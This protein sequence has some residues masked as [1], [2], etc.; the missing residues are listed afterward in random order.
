[1][2]HTWGCGMGHSM[3]GEAYRGVGAPIVVF[4]FAGDMRSGGRGVVGG[5]TRGPPCLGTGRDRWHL[6]PSWRGS[7]FVV[8]CIPVEQG[9]GGRQCP[10]QAPV[11]AEGSH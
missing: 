8:P 9:R 11:S 1:M 4:G 10:R 5:W 3:K 6:A 7:L 2:G